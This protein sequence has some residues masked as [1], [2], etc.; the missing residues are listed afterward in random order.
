MP[1]LS[2]QSIRY[3]NFTKGTKMLQSNLARS[4]S[5][6]FS[7]PRSGLGVCGCLAQICGL[8]ERQTPNAKHQTRTAN[9]IARLDLDP[10]RAVL[11]TGRR[12]SVF[13][14][15]QPGVQGQA[16]H[17]GR[18]QSCRLLRVPRDSFLRAGSCRSL[19]SDLQSQRQVAAKSRSGPRPPVLCRQAKE[20]KAIT[21]LDACGTLPQRSVI[22]KL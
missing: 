3:T 9:A 17:P 10:R 7:A 20:Q 16:Y 15:L 21:L 19:Y 2:D 18:S 13:H 12:G 8:L 22:G 5:P 11:P 14:C 6:E 4:W 1:E